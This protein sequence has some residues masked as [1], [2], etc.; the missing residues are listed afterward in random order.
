MNKLIIKK[1]KI[2][3]SIVSDIINN[4]RIDFS[5]DNNHISLPNSAEEIKQEKINEEEMFLKTGLKKNER[6]IETFKNLID[7]TK[8]DLLKTF[9]EP[10]GDVVVH[11]ILNVNDWGNKTKNKLDL[12]IHKTIKSLP[13]KLLKQTMQIYCKK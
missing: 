9:T 11:D 3:N 1:K 10:D 6:D 5:T 2:K 8:R 7:E 12:D 13:V 4:E